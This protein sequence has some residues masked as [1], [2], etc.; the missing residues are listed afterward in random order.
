MAPTSMAWGVG[1]M[2]YHLQRWEKW[3]LEQEGRK[4]IQP[5]TE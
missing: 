4:P 1:G 3:R 5:Q 2:W